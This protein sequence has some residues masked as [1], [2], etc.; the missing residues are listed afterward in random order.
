[1]ST[2]SV[3]RSSSSRT[4]GGAAKSTTADAVLVA[5]PGSRV[6]DFT[7]GLDPQRA[8]FFEH[9]QYVP[10]ELP[11]FT[12]TEPPAGVPQGVFYPRLE[13]SQIAALGYDVSSTNPDVSFL[14]VSMKTRHIRAQLEKSDD[15]DLDA[16]VDEASRRYPVIRTVVKD[17][18]VSRWRE[19]LPLF[20][21]GS[22]GRLRDFVALPP[23]AGRRVRGRLP[24]YGRDERRVRHGSA[25][26]CGPAHPV[27][28]MAGDAGDAG[29]ALDRAVAGGA[30]GRGP[31]RRG[32]DVRRRGRAARAR[33]RARR[34]RAAG[35]QGGAPPAPRGCDPRRRRLAWLAKPARRRAAGRRRTWSRFDYR[36]FAKFGADLARAGELLTEPDLV[37]GRDAR[38]AGARGRRGVPARRGDGDARLPRRARVG[39]VR[40]PAGSRGGVR[41]GA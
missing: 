41:P 37:E 2:S 38:R 24:L 31:S 32:R 19:A 8:H 26:G 7:Q 1:M 27:R 10:H 4:E 9:V 21:P 35:A 14:R 40:L 16:I 22:M 12:V 6:L 20:P 5:V 25:S 13:D 23:A 33:G 29:D 36:G 18:F 28:L 3:I 39:S 30:R 15:E 17:R 11:F 34:A